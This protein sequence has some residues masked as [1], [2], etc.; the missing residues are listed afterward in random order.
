MY[1]IINKGVIVKNVKTVPQIVKYFQ[2][3]HPELKGWS[4]PTLERHLNADGKSHEK[5]D[6]KINRYDFESDIKR[7]KLNP[8]VNRKF[9]ID[10]EYEILDFGKEITL[11]GDNYSDITSVV[12]DAI[13]KKAKTDDKKNSYSVII[14]GS[15]KSYASPFT[16]LNSLRN[17]VDAQLYKLYSDYD[18]ESVIKRILIRK[19]EMD[20]PY[21][22]QYMYGV[23]GN[24]RFFKKYIRE[25]NNP[26]SKYVDA[27]LTK[28]FNEILLNYNIVGS[29]TRYNC[30]LHALFS[31]LLE[32]SD[33]E[34]KVRKFLDIHKDKIDNKN[35]LYQTCDYFANHFNV[36]I[37]ST[38]QDLETYETRKLVGVKEI[39]IMTYGSHAYGM[40]SK[41]KEGIITNFFEKE[42][43]NLI[44]IKTNPSSDAVIGT[45]DIE[46][47]DG[48]KIDDHKYETH[49][50]ACGLYIKGKYKQFFEVDDKEN[51]IENML[52]SIEHRNVILYAHNGGKFDMW[53]ILKDIL[54]T[55]YKVMGSI[56]KDGR[57]IQLK[58]ESPHKQ[59]D[60][61]KRYITFRDSFTFLSSSLDSLCKEFKTTTQ[62]LTGDVDHDKINIINCKTDEIKNYVSK[63]LKND[64][65]SLYEI[66]NKFNDIIVDKISN[67]RYTIKDCITNAGIARKEF[68]TRW[69]MPNKYPLYNLDIE[70]DEILREFYYGGRNECFEK[71]GYIEGP[72]YYYDFTSLYPFCL[73]LDLPY[74]LHETIKFDKS[75]IWNSSNY[76]IKELNKYFGLVHCKVKHIHKNRRPYHALKKDCKLLFPYFENPTELIIT[77]EELKYSLKNDLGY[78]YEI[79]YIINYE[80]KAKYYKPYIDHL[81]KLK[82]EAEE[83]NQPIL[84]STAKII[85]NSSY[86]FWGIKRDTENIK[87]CKSK[88]KNKKDQ[89]KYSHKE[90]YDYLST[91]RLKD[92]KEYEGY[93]IYKYDDNLEIDCQNVGI[94]FFTC[95]YARTKLY[96]LMDNISKKGGKVYYC[97]TDSVI[98]DYCIERDVELKK[99]YITPEGCRTRLGDLTNETG[100]KEGYYNFL[101]TLGN[102]IYY[103]ENP[104]LKK[105]PYVKKFKGL[106]IKTG[107]KLRT[108]DKINKIIKFSEIVPVYK[109]TKDNH[110][111]ITLEDYKLINE[112]YT[113]ECETMTFRSG[114]EV[115]YK[116][117]PVTKEYNDKKFKK[118]YLKG[119]YKKESEDQKI[120]AYNI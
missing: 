107:Y 61:D 67:G 4:K 38:N 89:D 44:E 18:S 98:T 117:K 1:E 20:I 7:S 9:E 64:C 24:E 22:R 8:E 101:I 35:E 43:S 82:I 79:D 29:N 59:K 39:R 28:K 87:I 30:L 94:A 51:I 80:G 103:L 75:F 19:A 81:Y 70:T 60:K 91:E 113:L 33:V 68:L 83:S 25:L 120:E 104:E 76:D 114:T 13:T 88:A 47:C 17:I 99:K 57:I 53:V 110:I 78:E 77:T 116:D 26:D 48:E 23:N 12:I 66:I 102:K 97:D 52:K 119:K 10:D 84:R 56:I 37:I 105:T 5:G 40:I 58:I 95:A 90:L 69:Y 21:K 63:Y 6:F 42:T 54:K 86:G 85:I 55:N 2:D 115:I 34:S 93:N 31:S 118:Q 106:N 72:I 36:N 111:K 108:V 15:D 109:Q 45:Y 65:K 112:G 96:E 73:L 92:Y 46:T 32:R 49:L 16:N 41:N 71:L 62:K 74:G 100:E 50:Y 11:S 3:E 27:T 14:Y